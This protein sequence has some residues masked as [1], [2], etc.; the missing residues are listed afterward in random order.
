MTRKPKY[1]PSRSS[2]EKLFLTDSRLQSYCKWRVYGCK[3]RGT[4]H[5]LHEHHERHCTHRARNDNSGLATLWFKELVEN[6][7]DPSFVMNGLGK[8]QYSLIAIGYVKDL[9]VPFLFL[10]TDFF[11]KGMPTAER[12]RSALANPA[13]DAARPP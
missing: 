13:K 10:T 9:S 3:L 2:K 11:P 12:L 8:K 1:S 6:W 7:P 4:P 5:W